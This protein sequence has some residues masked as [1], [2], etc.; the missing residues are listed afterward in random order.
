MMGEGAMSPINLKV[1]SLQPSSF[2]VWI[3]MEPNDIFDVPEQSLNNLL[4]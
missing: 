3:K 4:K 1:D 2:G